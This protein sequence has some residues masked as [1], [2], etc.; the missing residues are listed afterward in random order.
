MSRKPKENVAKKS[1]RKSLWKQKLTHSVIFGDWGGFW[2][3]FGL[4]YFIVKMS[5]LEQRTVKKK[6]IANILNYVLTEA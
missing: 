3:E 1:I 2:P 4:W 6:K 5:P